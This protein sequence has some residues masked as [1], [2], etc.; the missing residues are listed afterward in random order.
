MRPIASLLL[1]VGCVAGLALPARAQDGPT[2]DE[3]IAK[4][5]ARDEG[6]H[7]TRK[8]TMTLTDKRGKERV[9]ETIGYRKYFGDEKRT[10]LFY[11]SPAN[12]RDTGFMTYDYPEYEVD[13]DQWL[14]LPAAR[15]VRRIS[16]SDR[17]DYFLGTDF[18]YEDIK[19]ESKIEARDYTFTLLGQEELDGVMTY[20]VEGIPKNEDIAQELGYGK[21]QLWVDGGIWMPRKAEFWD[22]RMNPLKTV[23]TRD[24]KQVDGIWT[25]HHIVAT[26]HKTGH[27]SDFRFEEID[28]NTDV[29]DTVFTQR[30]LRRGVT[31]S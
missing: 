17:G 14:Y 27:T 12:I 1:A 15:K 2:A 3:I 19:K 21:V 7:V 24:I 11:L 8:L 20:H 25:A 4:M 29:D 5:N 31:G 28:Y 6:E 22:V 18:S 26:N 16:A 23:R 9:R 30:A 10:V 13:D